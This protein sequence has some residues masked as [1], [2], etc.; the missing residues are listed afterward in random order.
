MKALF[1][2]VAAAAYSVVVCTKMEAGKCRLG[3]GVLKNI[4]KMQFWAIIHTI[5]QSK[6]GLHQLIY[7]WYEA[8]HYGI[9]FNTPVNFSLGFSASRYA[10][11]I[12]LRKTS[13]W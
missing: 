9:L 13:L 6:S 7:D 11:G 12:K 10:D 1:M 4:R 3:W 8:M 5:T 2:W